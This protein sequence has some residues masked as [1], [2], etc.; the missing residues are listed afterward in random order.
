M[1]WRLNKYSI[2]WLIHAVYYGDN[3]DLPA[4]S[5]DIQIAIY[6]RKEGTKIRF[7]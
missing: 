7:N 2:Q 4:G 5:A 1:S 6:Q 3:N